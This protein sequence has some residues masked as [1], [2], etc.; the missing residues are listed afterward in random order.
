[1]FEVMFLYY[2]MEANLKMFNKLQVYFSKNT[3]N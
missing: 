2:N 3:V 1:M